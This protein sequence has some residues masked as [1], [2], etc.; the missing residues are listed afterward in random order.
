MPTSLKWVISVGGNPAGTSLRVKP[1]LDSIVP[2]QPSYKF[3][4]AMELPYP[5][6]IDAKCSASALLILGNTT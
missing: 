2:D 4:G 1:C 3:Q 6:L 5:L